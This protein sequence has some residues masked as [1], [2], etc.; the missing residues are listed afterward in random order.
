MAHHKVGLVLYKLHLQTLARWHTILQIARKEEGRLNLPSSSSCLQYSCSGGQLWLQ[1][2]STALV[3]S[4][5][6]TLSA[7]L[8]AATLVPL[9]T[10]RRHHLLNEFQ[11][12]LL[13]CCPEYQ[14]SLPTCMVGCAPTRAQSTIQ[15]CLP[16]RSEHQTFKIP[17][18]Y[19]ITCLAEFPLPNFQLLVTLLFP[20]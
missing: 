14:P 6:H 13:F 3:A 15:P 11:L 17:F 9:P 7:M 19:L 16:Q 10:P 2:N 8:V 1:P 18:Q 5:Y 20:L 12:A 4:A